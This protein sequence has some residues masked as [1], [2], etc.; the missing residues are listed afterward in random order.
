MADPQLKTVL[1]GALEEIFIRICDLELVL[2]KIRD[3]HA[4][5]E[6]KESAKAILF[7]KSVCI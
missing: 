1:V 2:E 6:F 7:V 5:S 4:V 3:L